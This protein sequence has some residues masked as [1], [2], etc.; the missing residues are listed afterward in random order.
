MSNC[1]Y[2]SFGVPKDTEYIRIYFYGDADPFQYPLPLDGR[3]VKEV[4]V[5][6]TH[7]VPERT[8]EFQYD[9]MMDKKVWSACSACGGS[10]NAEY[11]PP[12]FCPHCGARMVSR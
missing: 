2:T 4:L 3:V 5:G 12:R 11:D 10:V 1:S 6:E 8:C 7:Y 9:G